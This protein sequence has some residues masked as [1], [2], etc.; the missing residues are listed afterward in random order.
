MFDRTPRRRVRRL[1]P[2]LFAVAA[3]SSAAAPAA[4]SRSV[5]LVWHWQQGDREDSRH[6]DR[7][8]NPASVVKLATSLWALE[9]LGAEHRFTTRFATSGPLEQG[10]VRGDLVVLGGGDPDFHLENAQLVVAELRRAGVRRVEGT[11]YVDDAFWI[12]WEGGSEGTLEDPQARAEK[13]AARLSKAWQPA[14]WSKGMRRAMEALRKERPEQVQFLELPVG[15]VAGLPP[16]G[17]E[18]APLVEHRS[19]PL[20]RMLKRFNDYS[21]NDIERLGHHLG[22]AE[23]MTAYF[24]KRWA[25]EEPSFASLSGLDRNRMTPRQVIRLLKELEEAATKAE[26]TLGDLLPVIGCGRTTLRNYPGLAFPAGSLTGKTGT[27]VKTDGGVVALAGVIDAA[28]G[29]VRFFV[30]A[31]GTGARKDLGRDAQVRWLDSRMRGWKPR[32]SDQCS[33]SWLSYTGAAVGRP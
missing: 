7:L 4:S 8:M 30:A 10:V 12:G 19:N 18:V 20:K 28:A 13:M 3:L 1:L 9:E 23:A 6:A 16:E 2:I 33:E 5:E 21:N 26:L 32:A 25:G 15:A 14:E 29:P 31:P 22:D 17:L 11:L 24:R 27:L